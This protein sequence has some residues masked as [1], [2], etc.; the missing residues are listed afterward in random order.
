MQ[1]AGTKLPESYHG[2]VTQRKQMV[3]TVTCARVNK[4]GLL[5]AVHGTSM[6]VHCTS[7]HKASHV[8]S[9]KSCL[10]RARKLLSSLT[11]SLL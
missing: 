5:I 2:I 11:L 6:V 1:A 3:G 9:S 8:Y 4:S 7:R 10:I